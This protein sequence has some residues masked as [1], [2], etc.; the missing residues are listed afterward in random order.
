LI[1]VH[2][3][4][5]PD[6]RHP[7]PTTFYPGVEAEGSAERVSVRQSSPL[8]L[9]QFRLRRLQLQKVKVDVLFADGSKPESSSLLLHNPKYP[10]QAVIGDESLAVPAGFGEFEVPAGFSYLAR[11]AVQC[12]SGSK[13]V[14]RESKP[15]QEI[16]VERDTPIHLVLTIPGASCQL[17]RPK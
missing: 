2:Y 9:P 6:A 15:V 7:F 13:I 10:D 3:Y 1:A 16:K 14:T 4:S 17:W 12:E 5:A 11:V 8:L